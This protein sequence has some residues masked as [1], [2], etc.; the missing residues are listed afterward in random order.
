M[1]T[2]TKIDLS[3]RGALVTGAGRGIGRA[4]ALKLAAAG[5]KVVVN[6]NSSQ[7]A[8]EEVVEAI[9]SAGG[10]ARLYQADVSKS[11]EVEAM[12]NALT[13]EWGAVDILVNNAGITRD[14]L[15]M[16]MSSN[17]WDAVI[18]TNLRSVYYCTK[19]VLRTMLR[20]KWGRIIS[21]SSVVGLTGN[22][23][24]ANYAAAK[25]GII[26]FTKS[27]ARE[28]GSRNITANAIAPGF[29]E[30]DITANLPAEVK[31][32]ILKSIPAGYYGQ[33]DD[34]A[35]IALFLASDLASYVTGQVV[36]AD[37]GMVMY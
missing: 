33:P 32:A 10:E 34:V 26:G 13:K 16:R 22:A 5:A 17:E 15:M 27:I 35:N 7:S 12:I 21:I 3:G 18:D 8:A 36:N 11:E 9:K 25:A 29:I 37:G 20:N 31:E 23:G 30:T 4:T 14:N 1:A 24:Q 19:A 28:V 2:G 6:Y